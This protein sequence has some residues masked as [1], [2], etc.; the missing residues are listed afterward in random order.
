[1]KKKGRRRKLE[2]P[3]RW[4]RDDNPLSKSQ[5][6]AFLHHSSSEHLCQPRSSYQCKRRNYDK[7]H[8]YEIH[9]FKSIVKS[10]NLPLHPFTYHH[11]LWQAGSKCLSL[12]TR[13]FTKKMVLPKSTNAHQNQLSIRKCINNQRSVITTTSIRIPY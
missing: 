4:H 8:N 10:A 12:N 2:L 1:M 7:D 9:A 11:I 3:Q 6:Y 5:Q 13:E